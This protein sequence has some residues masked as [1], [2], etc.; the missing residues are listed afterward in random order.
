MNKY[1]YIETLGKKAKVAS[2]ELSNLS[3]HKKNEVLKQFHSKVK[4]NTNLILKANKID[5]LNSKKNK[6]SDNL[7]DRSLLNKDRIKS[8]LNSIEEVISFKDPSNQI[9]AKWKR[10]NGLVINRMTIPIGVLGVIYEA[11]PNVTSD[12]SILSFKSGNCA[13]LRGGKEA[14]QSNIMISNLFRSSLKQKKINQDCIQLVNNSY[15]AYLRAAYYA[16]VSF[17]DSQLGVIMDSLRS[18][19][20]LWNNTIIVFFGDHGWHL[21]M[22]L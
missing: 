3:E 14:I 17:M 15:H 4:K 16:T 1:K 7:I 9:I 18:Y 19:P 11:R 2:E 12:V 20:T 5:I 8:I 6:L 13:I 22:L 10:P 21:G